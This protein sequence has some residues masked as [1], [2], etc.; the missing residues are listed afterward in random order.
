MVNAVWVDL[1]NMLLWALSAVG[2][3]IRW[4]KGRK[5]GEDG[6]RDEAA[7]KDGGESAYE[8]RQI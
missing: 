8:V 5:N 7:F 6:S 3:G 1:V 4:W 2:L